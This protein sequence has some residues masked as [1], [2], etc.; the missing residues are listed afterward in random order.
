MLAEAAEQ[1]RRELLEQQG[2]ER[3][4]HAEAVLLRQEE[5]RRERDRREA[6]EARRRVEQRQVKRQAAKQAVPAAPAPAGAT[7]ELPSKDGPEHRIAN[8]R[9][10]A[11]AGTAKDVGEMAAELIAGCQARTMPCWNSCGCSRPAAR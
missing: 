11:A 6:E 8:P 3:A 5:A 4:V 7:P 9:A 10:M 1:A 2:R